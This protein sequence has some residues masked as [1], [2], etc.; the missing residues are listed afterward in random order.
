MR[1]RKGL[2]A[3]LNPNK[4]PRMPEERHETL[5]KE[6]I[7]LLSGDGMMSAKEIAASVRIPEKEVYGHLEHIARTMKG[8]FFVEPPVCKDCG[9]VFKKREKLKK[10]G[11]CPVCKGERIAEPLFSIRGWQP[12]PERL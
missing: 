9:F 5:R 8:L 6:M 4:P 2:Q 3:P 10:P 1:P 7:S 11:K 12:P